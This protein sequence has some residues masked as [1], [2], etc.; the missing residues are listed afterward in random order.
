MIRTHFKD[1]RIIE[2]T[3]ES[4]AFDIKK[5]YIDIPISTTISMV[6]KQVDHIEVNRIRYIY[7][8]TERVPVEGLPTD[9]EWTPVRYKYIYL[10]EDIANQ[11]GRI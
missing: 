9:W 6:D 5:P 11:L 1:G 8:R 7:D 2:G 4:L 10:R 3:P